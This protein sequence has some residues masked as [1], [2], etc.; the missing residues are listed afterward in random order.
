MY[1]ERF[2]EIIEKFLSKRPDDGLISNHDVF[3]KFYMNE[4]LSECKVSTWEEWT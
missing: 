4:C 3:L 2:G 1:Q